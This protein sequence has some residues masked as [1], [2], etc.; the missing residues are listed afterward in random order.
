[1]TILVGRTGLPGKCPESFCAVSSRSTTSNLFIVT[2]SRFDC[3]ALQT[4]VASL[5]IYVRL[6]KRWSC[7]WLCKNHGPLVVL[8]NGSFE[9]IYKLHFPS[10]GSSAA[11]TV[12]VASYG[13]ADPSL[14]FALKS[15]IGVEIQI[16]DIVFV[17]VT[18]KQI[19]DATEFF[20]IAHTSYFCPLWRPK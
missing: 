17:V 5:L 10:V 19:R 16:P 15:L 9:N 14:E 6:P 18:G 4:S 2:D 13:Q 8:Q 7:F 1:M 3:D 12:S 11:S 20:G